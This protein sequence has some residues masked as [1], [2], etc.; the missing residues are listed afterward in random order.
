MVYAKHTFNLQDFELEVDLSIHNSLKSTFAVGDFRFYLLRDNPMK[1]AWEFSEGLNSLFD[2]LQ[3]HIQEHIL[4]NTNKQ[5]KSDPS[6]LHAIT[7]YLRDEEMN[8]IND[9]KQS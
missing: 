5:S 4:R 3:I 8:I 7:A 1:S 2:G 9:P 6:R